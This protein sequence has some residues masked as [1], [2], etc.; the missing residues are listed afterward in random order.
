MI[1]VEEAR[2]YYQDADP[3]HDFDHVLRVLAMAEHLARLE[4]ADLDVVRQAALLHDISRLSD[5]NK[6]SGFSLQV[7]EETDHAL[8]A[9]HTARHILAGD[10]SDFVDAVAHAIEAHRFRNDIEPRT[11]EARILFDADKLDAIGAVGVAR[12]FAYA[13]AFGMPLWGDPSADYRPGV[14]D[15]AHTPRHE[16]EVKLKQIKDRLY[17]PSGRRLAEQRHRFMVAFFEQMAAEVRGER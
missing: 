11:L 12:A 2:Q 1:T 14:S 13:G 17:T 10:P 3:V 15:E 7:P 8:L 9:A 16:F 4:G 5:D 6:S